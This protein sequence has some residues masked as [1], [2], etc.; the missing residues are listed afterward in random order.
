MAIGDKTILI[1][2]DEVVVTRLLERLFEGVGYHV[3]A[4]NNGREALA[5]IEEF[6]RCPDLI[7]TD[8]VMPEMDGIALADAVRQQYWTATILFMSGCTGPQAAHFSLGHEHLIEKPFMIDDL[9]SQ[10]K[11]LIG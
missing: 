5:A 6:G 11:A 9:L 10:V 4:A 7:L 2:D 1:V 3:L 8:V